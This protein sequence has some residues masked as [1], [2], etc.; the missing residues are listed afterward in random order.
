MQLTLVDL[1]TGAQRHLR[2][3]SA[4]SYNTGTAPRSRLFELIA[5]KGG[6]Q[7]LSVPFMQVGGTRGRAVSVAFGL[8]AAATVD[9]VVESPT[10]RRVKLVAASM[11]ATEGQNSVSW[12]GLDEGGRPV[13]AGM[14]RCR[15]LVS[16]P[17]GQRAI[18][19]RLVRIG[20]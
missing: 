16:T 11:A 15:V 8:T 7:S 14:Y 17:D 4:F 18:A 12:D 5:T 19:E 6:G 10:G 3:T 2:T 13:P 9:V 20:R 1:E